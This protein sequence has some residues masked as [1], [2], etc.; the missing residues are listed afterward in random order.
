MSEGIDPQTTHVIAKAISCSLK[1]ANNVIL[2][3]AKLIKL[4]EHGEIMLLPT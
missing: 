3:E 1:T 2:L 4:S